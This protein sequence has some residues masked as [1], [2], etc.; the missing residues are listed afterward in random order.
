MLNNGFFPKSIK[1]FKNFVFP[2]DVA[3]PHW[4]RNVRSFSNETLPQHWTGHKGPQYL[5]LYLWLP[6][7]PD[8]TLFDFFLRDYIKDMAFMPPFAT[9]QDDLKSRNTTAVNSLDE[10]I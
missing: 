8:H 7:S 3:A 1:I 6:I 5:T 2:Q 4:H 10:D 9:S